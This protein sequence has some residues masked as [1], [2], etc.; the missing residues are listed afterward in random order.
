M[1]KK[2][3]TI[4]NLEELPLFNAAMQAEQKVAGPANEY[5]ANVPALYAPRITGS[6]QQ[7]GEE[8]YV[9]AAGKLYRPH[10]Y[11]KMFVVEKGVVKNSRYKG[12]NPNYLLAD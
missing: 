8:F 10:L 6:V 4:D 12:E 7:G 5:H 11:N 2:L 3:I 9:D 1:K